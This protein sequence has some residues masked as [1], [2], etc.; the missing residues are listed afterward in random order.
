MQEYCDRS[1]DR[2]DGLVWG[3]GL[4]GLGVLFL[5]HYMGL[6]AWQS[7]STWWPA[8]VIGLGLLR[9]LTARRPRRIGGAVNLILLG[10][11]FM[12]ATNHWYGLT[13]TNSWPLALVAVGGGIV[14]RAIAS[15]FMRRDETVEVDV[16]V[17]P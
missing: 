5:L 1:F 14:A 11:W 16:H 3:L 9:L 13:W 15:F 12:V 7:W 17:V 8:L 4:I 6:L 2:W 10:C